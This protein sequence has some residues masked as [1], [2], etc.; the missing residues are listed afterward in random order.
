MEEKARYSATAKRRARQDFDFEFN[1]LHQF[2][3]IAYVSA[4]ISSLKLT[5]VENIPLPAHPTS[6]NSRNS[7]QI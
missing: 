3:L 6:V 2:G 1:D 4:S 7:S 5:S